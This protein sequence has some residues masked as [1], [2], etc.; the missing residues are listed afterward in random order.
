MNDAGSIIGIELANF[1]IFEEPTFI[2]MDRLTLLFGPNSAGK[3]SVQDA[4]ELYQLVLDGESSY[5]D[6]QGVLKRHWRRSGESKNGLSKRMLISVT[7]SVS[8]EYW[9]R[10]VVSVKRGQGIIPSLWQDLKERPKIYRS[11]FEF[12]LDPDNL[13][14]QF[15][16]TVQYNF[17]NGD[18]LLVG[19]I[20]NGVCVNITH[21]LLQT[22]KKFGKAAKEFPNLVSLNN[23]YL[24]LRG[25]VNGFQ[26]NG[27]DFDLRRENW[28]GLALSEQYKKDSDW[29]NFELQQVVHEI[30]LLAGALL[31]GFHSEYKFYSSK[32]DASRKV[33]TRKDL[34]FLLDGWDDQLQEFDGLGDQQYKALAA[35]LASELIPDPT[36]NALRSVETRRS[37]ADNINRVLLD[38]L[39]LEQGYR[40]DYDF[41]VLLNKQNSKAALSGK[42][43]D[44]S[45]LGFLVELYL[46]D[47]M[48]RKHAVEDVGSGIGYILP[49]LCNLFDY[50]KVSLDTNIHSFSGWYNLTGFIQQPE[51]H[52][53]PALQAALGDI[54]IES[55]SRGKQVLI[56]THSEHLLLRLLK[57]IRQT[58]LQVEIAPELMLR[59]DDLC[60]LYFDPALDGTTK[61][62]R[63]R[64]TEDGEF[65]DRWP[66]GF[67]G[68]RDLELFDE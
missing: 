65:M 63:L 64:I 35:S 38:H 15:D 56:E 40:L 50:S 13:K 7:Y 3:S 68:E 59:A 41:R 46:R 27:A 34:T 18:E 29:H 54:F 45:E 61:V 16:F 58:H 31:S 22:S 52:L 57:R 67:F 51:L 60:V 25:G 23:G 32:V 21:P 4:L 9:L 10:S 2:P 17:F 1:Q 33:P 49:V 24:T 8:D 42:T 20:D 47:S 62:K 39:F 6:I 55:S 36:L 11:Q 14:G 43:L 48:G 53:H 44:R 30:S 26:Y 5:E 12:I 28:F 37:Y 19:E 66:R